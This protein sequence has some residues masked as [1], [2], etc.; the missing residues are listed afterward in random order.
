MSVAFILW[1]LIGQKEGL[2]RFLTA[3]EDTVVIVS[4]RKIMITVVIVKINVLAI[5]L[6]KLDFNWHTYNLRGTIM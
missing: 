1:R 3:G 2:L 6:L 4:D 5:E